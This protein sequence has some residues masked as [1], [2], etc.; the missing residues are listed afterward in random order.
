MPGFD[1]TGPM[2]MGPMTGGGRGYCIG[3]WPNPY[4]GAGLR[5]P[6]FGFGR[7]RGYRNRY[8]LT[9]LPG[10]ARAGWGVY[11]GA[12]YAGF[13]PNYPVSPNADESYYDKDAELSMLRNQEAYLET[14]LKEVRAHLKELVKDETQEGK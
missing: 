11:P 3:Y 5:R 10:W 7:G 9:G 6:W 8:Y 2:G 12:A 4:M 14:A 1:G 13:A